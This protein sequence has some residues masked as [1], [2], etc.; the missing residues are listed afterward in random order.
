MGFDPIEK[1][2]IIKKM[3]LAVGNLRLAIRGNSLWRNTELWLAVV[4]GPTFEHSHLAITGKLPPG[5]N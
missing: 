5:I 4:G 2:K 3:L 1:S